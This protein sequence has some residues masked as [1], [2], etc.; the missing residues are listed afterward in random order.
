MDGGMA[1][2]M[3][4]P[5]ARHLV[6][7]PTGLN[8]LVAAPLTDAG[9]TPYRAVRRSLG[10]LPPGS[11]AVVVGVGGLGDLAV[12]ILRALTAARVVA[13]DL[14]TVALK[15]AAS[16]GAD[17]TLLADGE[18]AAAI[19]SYTGGLGAD[20]VLDFVGSDSSLALS[21]SVA[22]IQGDLTIVGLGGT[23]P[24][25]YGSVPKEL[26]I[27]RSSW[28]SRPELVEVLELAARNLIAPTITTF[29]LADGLSA[30]QQLEAGTL[31]GRGVIVP[32]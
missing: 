3:L 11:T 15:Q 18:C 14:R 24:V 12:Q 16:R 30:Y 7:L 1:E 13:V 31:V 8:P 20:V 4:V 29:P 32:G 2:Y 6:P 21:A 22:R 28:G 25:N 19:R 27:Q 17:L 23:L 9:L 10:K 5:A 26:S